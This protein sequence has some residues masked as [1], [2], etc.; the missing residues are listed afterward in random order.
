MSNYLV[1]IEGVGGNSVAQILHGEVP[2]NPNGKLLA[3]YLFGPLKLE[4]EDAALSLDA[5]ALKY[6][7]NF[8]SSEKS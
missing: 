2:L 1:L 6:S 8:I 5:L 4:G 3:K 7:R